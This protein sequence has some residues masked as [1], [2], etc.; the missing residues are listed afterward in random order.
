MLQ[1]HNNCRAGQFSIFPSNWNSSKADLSLIWRINYWFYD[2]S[3]KR[4]KQL[5]IKMNK[6]KTLAERQSAVKELIRIETDLITRQGFNPITRVYNSPA[7]DADISE[8]TPI[9]EALEYVY[10][11]LDGKVEK[12]T[13]LDI[14]SIL[15]Y[16]KPAAIALGYNHLLLKDLKRKHIKDILDQ[17]GKMKAKFSANNYNHYRK[18]LS[19]LFAELL[20]LDLIDVNFCTG[21]SKQKS[22]RR[23][24]ETLTVE[25]RKLVSEHLFKNYFSFWRFLNIFFHSGSRITEL[26]SVKE[27]D[28]DLYLQKFKVTVKKGKSFRQE[29]RTITDSSLS[30]W[31]QIVELGGPG[32]YLF[33]NS[34]NPGS[35]KIG[36]AQITKRW[37]VHVKEKLGITADFYSLKH[38]NLD[39][40]SAQLGLK[41]ASAMAGHSTPVITLNYAQ[42]EKERR[43]ERLRKVKNS[44]A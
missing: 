13:L 18:Y 26:L 33:S 41:D 1:L 34:L 16:I 37:R 11:Q 3:L 17:T 12:A 15:K 35:K 40:I 23:I 2:D 27:T 7:N 43:E 20:E 30:L 6:F 4:K 10:N 29:W 38:T 8:F 32:Q 19:I 42:G 21:I 24:R 22:L 36:R 31:Q 14:K 44:F 28:V 5:V 25:Q 39:E 9:L